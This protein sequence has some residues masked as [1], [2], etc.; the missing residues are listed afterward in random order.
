MRPVPRGLTDARRADHEG[1]PLGESLAQYKL[2]MSAKAGKK[3]TKKLK[4]NFT[5][6]SEKPGKGAL[7]MPGWAPQAP[8]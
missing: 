7:P 2:Q 6:P 3:P 4:A 8:L 5:Y 1:G